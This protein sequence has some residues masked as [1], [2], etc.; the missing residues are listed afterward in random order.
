MPNKLNDKFKNMVNKGIDYNNKF[1]FI[2]FIINCILLIV[3]SLINIFVSAE[4]L[5]KI[6]DYVSVYNHIKNL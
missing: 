6:D 1:I 4:L 3:I 5:I 2:M